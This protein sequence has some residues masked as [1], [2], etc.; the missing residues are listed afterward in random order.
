[1]EASIERIFTAEMVE[2]AGR[3]FQVN[4]GNP[5]KLGDA[6]NY[7]F[8]VYR[9]GTPY[10][11]RLTH[12]SHRAK[13]QVLAELKWMEY[14]HNDGCAVPKVIPSRDHNLVE[15]V[16]GLDGS[17]FHCCLFE[18]APGARVKL[19]DVNHD[20]DLFYV[21][22]KTIGQLHKK[23]K[24]YIPEKVY[25]RMDWHEEELLDA[26]HYQAD[27][28]EQVLRQ[29][30]VITSKL[31]ALPVH[32]DNFGLIHSDIHHGNFHYHEGRIHIFDFDDCSNHWFASDLAIPLYY[33]IGSLEREGVEDLDGYAAQFMRA[34][35]KG[36]ETEN[37]LAREDYE[38]IPLF[39]KVRDLTLYNFFHKK[40]D[41]ENSDRE[42][43]KTVRTIEKRIIENRPIVHFDLDVASR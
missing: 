13:A 2:L 37:K 5:V 30:E 34:F 21:W 38:T 29:Q 8:E 27:A 36:Y 20:G 6:E 11:L 1:M 35:M 23:T 42:W 28:P 3:Y 7:V 14:L 39:L 19:T 10:I 4:T 9:D 31:K 26:A 41:L 32:R 24:D 40:Y 17:E 33:L 22:G 15:M 43:N 25:Q 16:K 18:K 12:Q